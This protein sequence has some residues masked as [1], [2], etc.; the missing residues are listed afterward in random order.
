MTEKFCQDWGQGPH[1]LKLGKSFE[2]KKGSGAP[3]YNSIRYDFKPTSIDQEGLGTLEVKDGR[4][5]AVS[6]PHNDG[7]GQTTYK[8]NTE[9]APPKDCVLI[10]D[11]ETGELTLERVT[12]NIRVKKTRPE[13]RDGAASGAGISEP[14]S[15]PYEV[16]ANPANPY[17][18][19]ANPA[20]PYEVKSNPTNP[21]APDRQK[22]IS[23]SGGARPVTPQAKKASPKHP[24]TSHHLADSLSPI[25]SNK[26]SP[27]S[28][29]GRGPSSQ[30]YNVDS[31]GRPLSSES[32]SESSDSDSDDPDDPP[33]VKPPKSSKNS[34]SS[35]AMPSAASTAAASVNQAGGPSMP[36][37]L[38]DLLGGLPSSR[39]SK[40]SKPRVSG[41]RPPP[42]SMDPPSM[43]PSMP[44]DLEDLLGGLPSPR[45]SNSSKPSR[46]SGSRPLPPPA[47]QPSLSASAAPPPRPTPA[48]PS[49]PAIF[50]GDD[51][52]LSD[53]SE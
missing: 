10:I 32:S 1:K 41:G 40:S 30:G 25:N 2:P 51:L 53:D 3:V 6:L 12:N 23:N 5:V 28:T 49:M 24:T 38:E 50:L 44:G 13:K 29:S 7:V 20:N 21:R 19:K 37:D 18:V 35:P 22:R 33:P 16:K 42:P 14:T 36:G 39:P 9:P 34:Q 4:S 8:G 17:E 43:P 47:S 48:Q 11:H 46:V 26:S 45:S 31:L 52:E 15:N 27:A